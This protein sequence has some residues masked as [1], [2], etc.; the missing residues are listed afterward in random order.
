MSKGVVLCILDG[1]GIS[2]E[3]RVSLPLLPVEKSNP[4]S[5]ARVPY[6]SHLFST[7]AYTLLHASGKYVGVQDEVIGNS[8]VG[9]TT[10]GAGN[11]IKQ[12]G[13]KVEEFISQNDMDSSS[14]FTQLKVE[15]MN[16]SSSNCHV[17]GMLSDSKVHGSIYHMLA[18]AE[19]LAK[20]SINVVL[21]LITDGRDSRRGE[22]L[23]MVKFIN[24]LCERFDNIKV[25]TLAGRYYAMDRDNRWDRTEKYCKVLYGEEY[26]NFD[27]VMEKL[28]ESYEVGV[29]DEFI[30]PSTNIHYKGIRSGDSIFITNYRT[31]RI[32]QLIQ[33]ISE[34]HTAK[35]IEIKMK[36]CFA[37]IGTDSKNFGFV[38]PINKEVVERPIGQIIENYGL[39]QLRISETEKYA[40]VTYFLNCGRETPYKLEERILIPSPKVSTYDLKPEMSAYEMTNTL[41][42]LLIKG[43]YKFICVNYPNLD[44]VGHTGDFQAAVKACE[45]ID[46]CVR[47][48][49]EVCIKNEYEMLICSDHG[50]IEEMLFQSGEVNT[51]HT[52]N[53]VPLCY[54]GDKS[55]TFKKLDLG[56]ANIAST[57]LELLNLPKEPKMR[58]SCILK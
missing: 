30:K 46:H 53:V 23:K 2:C 51:Q 20:N 55:I 9:H 12:I 17:I 10:I 5:V 4:L 32:R 28:K 29:T 3:H 37:P 24:T 19:Y 21:H 42:G 15:H 34:Y 26:E 33:L 16:N 22:G 1:L 52:T 39:S 56:L 43:E 47:E 58:E 31:D 40:H 36:V 8:E 50:N 6:L 54:V 35:Y 7:R 57:V 45:A 38:T 48:L 27:S 44:M 13:V 18:V 41:N 25:G 11:I 14:I 49:T